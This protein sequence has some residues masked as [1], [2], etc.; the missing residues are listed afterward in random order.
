MI[1]RLLNCL[2]TNALIFAGCFLPPAPVLGLPAS[3]CTSTPASCD[4]YEDGN[5]LQLPFV[6]IAGDVVLL[7]APS[8]I[9]DV[10]RVFNNLLDTGGGTGLGTEAFLF[11][12]DESN[13][14]SIL[15]VN[16]VS[17]PEGTVAV[18][19]LVETD[20]N[21]NGTIYRIFSGEPTAIP[22]PATFALLGIG[23]AGLGFSGRKRK[24]V[25]SI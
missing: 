11:S 25:I 20:F 9:S 19:G 22:E 18:G 1:I 17:I 7:D 16:A 23:L 8:T 13:L 5:F 21:G 10:F 14:P 15:S 24:A 6:A 12:A 3:S 4:V 2:T